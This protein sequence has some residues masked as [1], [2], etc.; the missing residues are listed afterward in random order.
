[1]YIVP[2]Q[3]SSQLH[4][5]LRHLEAQLTRL[6]RKTH[7][8]QD[9]SSN[10]ASLVLPPVEDLDQLRREMQLYVAS[11]GCMLLQRAPD[12]IAAP[13]HPY[14]HLGCS[15]E[16]R[17]RTILQ[18]RPEQLRL[19]R[20]LVEQR[21]KFLDPAHPHASHEWFTTEENDVC[22]LHFF[23]EQIRGPHSVE[24]AFS[25]AHAFIS[26]YK[27]TAKK[28]VSVLKYHDDSEVGN[29]SANIQLRVLMKTPDGPVIESNTLLFSQYDG[30]E[31]V[32][33]MVANYV[34]RDDL[35]PHDPTKR[36]VQEVSAVFLLS[37]PLS[38]EGV[39]LRHWVFMRSR[40]APHLMSDLEFGPFARENQIHTGGE[41]V[42]S[43]RNE[44]LA[45]PP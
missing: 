41:L 24:Q 11:L 3:E 38:G 33:I 4:D 13:V 5:E 28:T 8:G 26:D 2:Q 34:D 9:A 6:K 29:Q 16:A 35:R 27:V 10:P 15:M 45:R 14:I 32:G 7:Q 25:A 12:D 23:V 40:H 1:M 42:Q 44:L 36:F 19:G 31:N 39:V 20:Q 18:I 30:K 43:V 22:G 37:P 17:R 21:S